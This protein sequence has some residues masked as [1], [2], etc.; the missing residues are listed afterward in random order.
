MM[1]ENAVRDEDFHQNDEEFNK[2]L[3]FLAKK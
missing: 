2:A 3:E 1:R